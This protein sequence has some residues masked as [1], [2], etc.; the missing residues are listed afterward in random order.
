MSAPRDIASSFIG[1]AVVEKEDIISINMI[2]FAQMISAA[3]DLMEKG[4]YR[5]GQRVAYIAYR[6]FNTI[7]PKG[8]PLHIIVG[9]YLHDI[10][11]STSKL[12]AE[13]RNFILDKELIKAHCIDG[14]MLI[15]DVRLLNGIRQIIL[16]HHTNYAD[17]RNM[18]EMDSILEAQIIHLADRIDVLIRNDTYIL[19]QSE[20]IKETI[21]KYAGTMFHPMLVNAFLNLAEK[22]SFWFDIINERNYS[23]IKDAHYNRK[24]MM[25]REDIRQFADLCGKMVDRKSPYTA[26]HSKSVAKIASKLGVFLGMSENDVFYLEIA[27]LLHDLGKLSIP[28]TILHK[29]GKLSEE[30]FNIIKQ[31]TYHTYQLI[32]R[33]QLMDKVRDWAAFHH[34]KLDGSGYPF[35]KRGQELDLGA[36]IMAVA[37]ISAA[38]SE[39]RS[40]RKKMD[41]EE[42]LDILWQ[43]VNNNWIDGDVVGVLE[44]N[45]DEIV[46]G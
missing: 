5:H 3:A 22:E 30:E 35:H 2:D 8:D 36:R 12:K 14:E 13:A 27:G 15:Q 28:E 11:I 21:K 1:T 46:I 43:Q 18:D 38:L 37:D 31:H 29:P 7:N 39:D 32:D 45:F 25:K 40:Y 9:S 19:E 44:R 10:G 20:V 42:I 41:K 4:V 34:E 23:V 24:F 33:L 17:M 16:H 26:A 6:L